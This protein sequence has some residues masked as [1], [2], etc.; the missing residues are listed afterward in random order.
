MVKRIFLVWFIANFVLAGIFDLLTGGWYLRLP[1]FVGMIAELGLI[2]FPNLIIPIIL[3]RCRWPTPISN[4]RQALGWEWK[5]WRPIFIGILAF[6]IYL[7]LSNL[8]T[9]ILGPSI[10]YNLPG[11][12]GSIT[13]PAGLFAL[14]AFIIFIVITVV[15]EE[16]MFRGFIQT[17]TSQYYGVWAGALLTI[18]LFGLRHFP[19]DLFYANIWNAT[20][21]MWLAREADLYLAAILLSLARYFGRSTYASAAMHLLIFMLILM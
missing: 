21:R 13:G 1:V 18:V 4:F 10:P 9:Y 16:T 17:Q 2:I 6:V 12:G 20:P 15:G 11:E 19:A 7:L 5:G 8:L 3:L 14:F